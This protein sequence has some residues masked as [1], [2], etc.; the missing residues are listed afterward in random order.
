MKQQLSD[1]LVFIL[2]TR[3]KLSRGQRLTPI[4]F[5]YSCCFCQSVHPQYCSKLK[6]FHVWKTQ[7]DKVWSL[8]TPSPDPPTVCWLLQKTA[9]S[10]RCLLSAELKQRREEI[11]LSTLCSCQCLFSQSA[12]QSCSG[13]ALL[14]VTCNGDLTRCVCKGESPKDKRRKYWPQCSFSVS[15]WL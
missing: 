15:L 13:S 1:F 8:N 7:T 6:L 11:K 3:P 5:L 14:W 2:T 12:E 4:A 10:C 9:P